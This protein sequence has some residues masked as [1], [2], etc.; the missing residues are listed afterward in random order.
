MK[1]LA[2][3]WDFNGLQASKREGNGRQTWA[4]FFMLRRLATCFEVFQPF[5]RNAGYSTRH[6][7]RHGARRSRYSDSLGNA[8]STMRFMW[9]RLNIPNRAAGSANSLGIK[10]RH[11]LDD[12]E[13]NR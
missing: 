1:A 11:I 13:S 9:L 10:L 3:L 5:P 8:L 4:A 12:T 7:M 2:V 6:G